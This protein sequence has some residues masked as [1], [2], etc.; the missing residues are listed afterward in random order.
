MNFK[1]LFSGVDDGGIAVLARE[2]V[3]VYISV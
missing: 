2:S 3:V 1:L